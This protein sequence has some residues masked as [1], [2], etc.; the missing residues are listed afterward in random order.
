MLFQIQRGDGRSS[1]VVPVGPASTLTQKKRLS[2]WG[3]RLVETRILNLLF[4]GKTGLYNKRIATETIP[5]I[6]LVDEG[7]FYEKRHG[8]AKKN[9]I[10]N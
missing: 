9:L 3:G 4:M 6:S 2:N 1:E 7:D 5:E 10:A 8:F